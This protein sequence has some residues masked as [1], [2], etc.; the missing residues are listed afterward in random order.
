MPSSNPLT[1]SQL[2]RHTSFIDFPSPLAT[3]AA[4]GRL[5]WASALSNSKGG[6]S[7]VHSRLAHG[8]AWTPHP[9]VRASL[10]KT[11]NSI[12][13]RPKV[14]SC[15]FIPHHNR[16]YG[17]HRIG[18]HEDGRVERAVGALLLLAEVL[19]GRVVLPIAPS[20][21]A[22]RALAEV[23]ELPQRTQC[24]RLSWLRWYLGQC[25]GHLSGGP[26][27]LP[28]LLTCSRGC[29][30]ICGFSCSCRR[31]C[32]PL[33]PPIC[34]HSS[35]QTLG[36]AAIAGRWLVSAAASC[37][38][39]F[40]A[41]AA[42][43]ASCALPAAR[44]A[45]NAGCFSSARGPLR[46]RAHPAHLPTSLQIFAQKHKSPSGPSHPKP[47]LFVNNDHQDQDGGLICPFGPLFATCPQKE[48]ATVA[49]AGNGHGDDDDV[50]DAGGANL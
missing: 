9:F 14:Q 23:E 16:T 17:W 11:T 24:P 22:P 6:R 39:P 35:V 7:C 50:H 43:A 49:L 13:V 20:E 12:F 42:L 21:C 47:S 38:L 28:L 25:R 10:S 15:F 36:G 2:G 3:R 29:G 40:V 48:T 44:G 46:R 31:C 45:A 41:P 4:C 5:S 30:L 19:G 8:T 34:G 18:K 33:R 26:R 32:G 1:K 37:D 27:G